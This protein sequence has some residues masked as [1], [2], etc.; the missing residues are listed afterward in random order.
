M[1]LVYIF[2]VEERQS[3]VGGADGADTAAHRAGDV[4]RQISVWIDHPDRGYARV[5]PPVV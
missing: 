3:N 2:G 1:V 5:I 4:S